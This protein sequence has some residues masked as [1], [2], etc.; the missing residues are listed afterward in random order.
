MMDAL[1]SIRYRFQ[2]SPLRLALIL[3]TAAIGVGVLGLALT[4]TFEISQLVQRTL[5]SRGRLVSI[6]NGTVNAHGDLVRPGPPAITADDAAALASEYPSLRDITPV[7]PTVGG[8]NLQVGSTLYQARSM[9]G[10]GSAYASL[11]RLQI[12]EGS[13]F[14]AADETAHNRV[15][16]L[17]DSAARILFGTPRDAV[18]RQVSSLTKMVIMRMGAGEATPRQQGVV[19]QNVFR[20]VGVF[21]DVDDV[22]RRAFGI[23]DIL[24]PYSAILP[25]PPGGFPRAAAMPSQI[26]SLMARVT[27]D[28][29]AV[30]RAKVTDILQ[31]AHGADFDV[32]LWEGNPDH[33]DSVIT[34]ARD[35]LGRFSF[36][37]SGLGALVLVVSSFGIFSIMLVETVDRN[38][39]IG[40]RRAVGATRPGIMGLL[41]GQAAMLSLAGAVVGCVLA[42]LFHAPLRAALAPYLQTA[43]VGSND[44]SPG[45]GEAAALLI[46]AAGAVA[47]GALFA[48]LPAGLASRRP[49]VEC[50]RE[51]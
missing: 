39:E 4:V 27:D 34:D 28:A 47:M 49:I 16:V 29:V 42:L 19:A 7:A 46:A 26:M 1:R 32:A 3:L 25:D 37:L 51:E 33:P 48:L 36:L 8:G 6:T 12:E 40:L 5:P 9:Q 13:F 17:S 45:L 18:G 11:M 35:S 24:V 30:A 21:R 43:G 44:L 14:S 20:V 10:V 38:R 23:G 22:A 15:A 41:A 2:R 31:R 50:L